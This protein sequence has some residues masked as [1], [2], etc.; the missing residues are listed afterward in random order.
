MKTLTVI[1]VN[2]LRCNCWIKLGLLKYVNW[3]YLCPEVLRPE[4][5]EG[6]CCGGE[7]WRLCPL[8]G[9]GECRP[10]EFRRTRQIRT[11]QLKIKVEKKFKKVEKVE[12]EL[13][14]KNWKAK[15]WNSIRFEARWEIQI[16][17]LKKFF[18]YRFNFDY[19]YTQIRFDWTS[20][21]GM[22]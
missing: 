10:R 8:A 17:F 9:L 3:A 22:K 13:K 11:R 6:R 20:Y 12:K 1:T 15:S 18:F 14:N 2:A 16:G 7:A 19:R 5:D 21:L 4:I